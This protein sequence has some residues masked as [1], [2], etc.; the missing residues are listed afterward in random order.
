MN[1][2]E[3]SVYDEYVYDDG[4]NNIPL[5]YN[6]S[7]SSVPEAKFSKSSKFEKSFKNHKN[8]EEQDIY[9]DEYYCLARSSSSQRKDEVQI[10]EESPLHYKKFL[11][12]CLVLVILFLFAIFGGFV[13]SLINRNIVLN[14]S[15]IFH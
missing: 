8:N 15:T 14:I 4:A 3:K 11:I 12:I 6:S 10:K 9:D 2:T 7:P 13:G 5:N 1:S